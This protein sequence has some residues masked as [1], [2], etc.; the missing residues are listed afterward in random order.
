MGG[1]NIFLNLA[2]RKKKTIAPLT[3]NIQVTLNLV[4]VIAGLAYLIFG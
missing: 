3:I 1:Y 2:R 4:L